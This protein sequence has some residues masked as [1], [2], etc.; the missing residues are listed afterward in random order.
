MQIQQAKKEELMLLVHGLKAV[1]VADMENVRTR[2]LAQLE[3]ELSTRYGMR[4]D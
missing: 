1:Y 3:Q 4:V 2:L